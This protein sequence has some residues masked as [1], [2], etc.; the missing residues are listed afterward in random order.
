MFKKRQKKI[1]CYVLVFDQINIVKKSLNFLAKYADNLDIIVIEN[2]SPNTPKIRQTIEALGSKKLIKQYY[3]FEKNITNNAYNIVLSKDI[4]RIRKQKYVMFTDGDLT[5]DNDNWLIEEI[6]IL[7]HN[8]DVFSCGI[9]LDESNLPIKSF[10]DANNWIPKDI[11][12][13]GDY[14]E[15]Y[16]GGHLLL[17]RGKEF[18]SFLQWKELNNQVFIDSV[19][20][21]YCYDIL[22]K[23]WARTKHAKA[24]HHTWDLYRY[25]NNPYTKLKI[26][27]GFENT[28][29]HNH[30]ANYILKNY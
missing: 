27:K 12:E 26:Q 29:K 21:R 14:F 9:S 6:K 8:K 18:A 19:M 30:T 28:W 5:C 1:L 16:T 23:K 3:L 11:D 20:H 10:P 22:N 17:F 24:Y 15:A 2:P 4:A 25:K 7:E 13:K